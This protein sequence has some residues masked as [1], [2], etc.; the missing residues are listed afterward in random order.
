MKTSKICRTNLDPR[1]FIE[2]KLDFDRD[3]TKEEKH[4][5]FLC[6]EFLGAHGTEAGRDINVESS[7][8]IFLVT[9]QLSC[10]TNRLSFGWT[11]A[12]SCDVNY[13]PRRVV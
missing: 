4:P 3:K 5:P 7:R 12:T 13:Y 6:G 10:K 8:G 9:S 11:V 2:S 1:V